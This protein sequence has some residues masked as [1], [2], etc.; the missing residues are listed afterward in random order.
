MKHLKIKLKNTVTQEIIQNEILVVYVGRE[1]MFARVTTEW[2]TQVN[3]KPLDFQRVN[4]N[5][6]PDTHV[7][8]IWGTE[9]RNE[10]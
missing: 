7:V 4:V 5:F 3:R 9:N 1:I 6:S 10:I 2:L 8:R